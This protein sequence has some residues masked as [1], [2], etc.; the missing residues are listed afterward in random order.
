MVIVSLNAVSIG[1]GGQPLLDGVG[2]QIESGER[3][4]LLGRNGEGKSTLLRLIKGEVSPDEGEVERRNGLRVAMLEQDVPETEDS[5]SVLSVILDGFGEAGRLM[6]RHRRMTGDAASLRSSEGEIHRLQHELDACDGWQTLHRAEALA[7][8][9]DLDPNQRFARL[10]AGQKRRVLLAAALADDPDLLLLDEPTNHLD[11]AAIGWLEDHLAKISGTLLFVTHDR[12]FLGRL[13]TRILYLDRAVLTSYPCDFQ[14]FIQRRDAI[15]EAE[16]RSESRFDQK[17]AQ[18]EGWIRQGVKARRRRNQGR[19]KALMAMREARRSRRVAPGNLK[20]VAQEAESSGKLVIEARNITYRWQEEPV[21]DGF[22]TLIMRGDRVGVIGPG[23]S[24]K[25]TLLQ[26]LLGRLTPEKGTVRHGT[27]LEI[28]YFDQLRNQL[29]PEATVVRSVA[30]GNDTISV[31]GNRRHVIGYLKDFLFSPERARSPVKTLSGGERN[32]LL[33]ARI[34]ARPSNLLVLDEP[35]NDLDIETLELLEELLLDYSGTLIVVSH[36]R[37]FLNNVVTSILAFE[38][39]GRIGEYI[40]GYDDWERQRS[41]VAQLPPPSPPARGHRRRP[42]RERKLSFKEK[43]ELEEL[44]GRIEALE[45]EREQLFEAMAAP[46]FYRKPGEEI[47]AAK[48]RLEAVD[49][50]LLSAYARWE[51]LESMEP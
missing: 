30:D 32:R 41:P 37:A 45:I 24:G 35:T 39:E 18:E 15:L 9:M 6:D 19:L 33:L 50:E 8:R 11:I 34:L 28:A 47:R 36:D 43:R 17:L 3:I 25:S 4:G 26:I 22:S 13:A 49:R 5:R 2:L 42:Q 48:D 38:G 23:G 20:A 1:F 31:N 51:E 14:T 27:R 21:I 40:G 44:P 29:D 16:S 10:S 7:S 12:A 46:D